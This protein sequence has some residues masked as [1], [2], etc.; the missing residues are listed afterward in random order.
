MFEDGSSANSIPYPNGVVVSGS[1]TTS[2]QFNHAGGLDGWS[3]WLKVWNDECPNMGTI[4]GV[5][6]NAAVI[7]IIPDPIVTTQPVTHT[8]CNG[9]TTSFFVEAE[10]ADQYQWQWREDA[11]AWLDLTDGF[12]PRHHQATVTGTN[13][14]TLTIE[15]AEPT[16]THFPYRVKIRNSDLN[17]PMAWVLSDPA[18]LYVESRVPEFTYQPNDVTVCSDVATSFT[19]QANNTNQWVWQILQNNVW[20]DLTDSEGYDE[21]AYDGEYTNT[22]AINIPAGLN[23]NQYRVVARINGCIVEGINSDVVTLTVKP[24]PQ[25]V[26][27]PES[28]TVCYTEQTELEL[29]S[30]AT[31]VDEYKWMTYEGSSW[32]ELSSVSLLA[33]KAPYTGE[34]TTKLV[35]EINGESSTFLNGRQFRL[36]ARM[37]DCPNSWGQSSVATIT[38]PTTPSFTSQPGNATIECAFT[39][40]SFTATANNQT[41]YNWQRFIN[42]NWVN[43]ANQTATN[44]EFGYSG[45]TTTTLVVT[46]PLYPAAPIVTE[47]RL[48]ARNVGCPDSYNSSNA[49]TL[50]VIPEANF[51]GVEMGS[52]TVCVVTNAVDAQLVAITYNSDH[53]QWEL[54]LPGESSWTEIT[55][56]AVYTGTTTSALKI[57]NPIVAMDGYSYKLKIWNDECSA[58]ATDVVVIRV[59]AT[60]VFTVEPVEQTIC[61]YDNASFTGFAPLANEYM[62]QI[63]TNHGAS[64]SFLTDGGVYSGVTTTKLDISLVQNLGGNM[65]RLGAKHDGC[66]ETW[67]FSAGAVL[68]TTSVPIF[69]R[70]PRSYTVC[71][72]FPSTM[73]AQLLVGTYTDMTWQYRTAANDGQDIWENADVAP[74]ESGS[75]K[76]NTLRITSVTNVRN[77]D[78]YSYR[79]KVTNDNCP[80]SFA[81][82]D[83]AYI[84]VPDIP[85]FGTGD[86]PTDATVC[87][88]GSHVFTSSAQNANGFQWQIYDSGL[89]QWNNIST[90]NFTGYNTAS[91]TILNVTSLNGRRFRVVASND[92]CYGVASNDAVLTVIQNNVTFTS[93][94]SLQN[95]CEG[96]SFSFS[97]TASNATEYK[98]QYSTDGTNWTDLGETNSTYTGTATAAMNNR[99]IKAAAKNNICDIWAYSNSARLYVALT[100]TFS[101]GPSSVVLC[102]GV[103]HTFA[104]TVSNATEYQWQISIDGGNNYTNISGANATTY[105]IQARSSMNGYR[106][107]LMARNTANCDWAL[108]TVAV[109][110]VE[111]AP[112]FGTNAHPQNA[113]VCANSGW[114][115][116]STPT[117]ADTYQWQI[118]DG[119]W[120]NLANGGVY[121]GVTTNS[122]A[123]SNV[124]GLNG[125]QYRLQ[126]Q[127]SACGTAWVASNAAQINVLSAPTISGLNSEIEICGGNAYT[128]N[129]TTTNATSWLWERSTNGGANWTTIGTNEDYTISTPVNGYM[130]RLTATNN[131][132][133]ANF[134]VTVNV[135]ASPEFSTDPVS[136]PIVCVGGYHRYE[137]TING[138]Y[139]DVRWR[140][141]T[142]G[143][144]TWATVGTGLSYTINSVATTHSGLYKA[145]VRIDGCDWIS[146]RTSTLTVPAT[147]SVTITPSTQVLCLNSN[148]TISASATPTATTYQWQ[149][150]N[151]GWQNIVDG[152]I[153]SGY[154]TQTLT[155]TNVQTTGD[156]EYRVIVWN[157]GCPSGGSISNVA[158]ITVPVEPT[159]TVHP[160]DVELYGGGHTFTA[161]TSPSGLTY[162]WQVSDD[163]TNWTNINNGG[164]YSGATTASLVISNVAN[165]NGK[166]YRL[167]ANNGGCPVD[168]V[169]SNSALLTVQSSLPPTKIAIVQN[170][171]TQ[172][173]GVSFTIT[174]QTLDE[175]NNPANVTAATSVTV[176]KFSGDGNGTISGSY[177]TGTISAGNSQTTINMTY[178]ASNGETNV[179]LEPTSGTFTKVNS[180]AFTV[181]MTPPS[182]QASNI[183]F[184]GTPGQTSLMFRWTRGNGNGCIVLAKQSYYTDL[185][186]VPYNGVVYNAN[187]VF[188]SGDEVP[189]ASSNVWAVYRGT[190]TGVIVTGLT[191]NTQYAF[192]VLEYNVNNNGGNPIYSYNTNTSGVTNNPNSRMTAPRE[193]VDEGPQ[194]GRNDYHYS[195]VLTVGRIMPNPATDKIS[196]YISLE[197]PRNVNISIYSADGRMVIEKFNNQPMNA[198]TH[199][200][201]IP[202]TKYL[203]PGSYTLG[204]SA[205]NDVII[206]QFIIMK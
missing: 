54:Q 83:I 190:G 64:Y 189:E 146:S 122:L 44:S 92:G 149:I 155:I 113:N 24:D 172:V 173:T 157:N 117:N 23:G 6:S 145:E 132:G 169:N 186:E 206:D 20:V 135:L 127:N 120:T 2:L 95:V 197:E 56:G 136:G 191:R 139:T 10:N 121:S 52:H 119:T 94:P 183:V 74:Y 86:S 184:V 79:L 162:R 164:V 84:F 35:F 160:Q 18:T 116:T 81:Y 26:L 174:V 96:A 124:N 28:A 38:V 4:Y 101:N 179:V 47:Y 130:Y 138:A 163:N 171:A 103:G 193:G 203:A 51:G 27:H 25:F 60:P 36:Y 8:V 204:V 111:A 58:T 196:F 5:S 19:A 133:S 170:I 85:E 159:F 43:L 1:Q 46:R 106:Y 137:V 158:T 21:D 34:F 144:S 129:A 77:L 202:F 22:L 178:L 107:R 3:I 14:A 76:T 87:V 156:Y 29:T 17:C 187:S 7:T 75:Y 91:L 33:T 42:G 88:G 128:L 148:M 50:T 37:D 59:P 154:T 151:G 141:S 147:P 167:N 49:A 168:G 115:F 30:Y 53:W 180:N 152:G 126:A 89:N 80:S 41:T 153:Y 66:P 99:Y 12:F 32:V 114:T 175:N 188:M 118:L 61:E 16:I 181:V 102:D 134:T 142:D 73:D 90:S 177:V 72:P 57:L 70:Q 161:T 150:N 109:L 182:R 100:P 31:V 166:H 194:A 201:E 68:H 185:T 192:K 108:S 140:F 45:A 105:A 200:I 165:L 199:L 93:Q 123:I 67:K 65:Y 104:S 69:T 125:K 40:A 98:W 198:G 78:G 195:D 112:V 176:T 9:N 11:F 62:W 63:S 15:N 55:D 39:S 131:C 97:A 205:G 82:S 13:T 110:T 48:G 71:S 143:G